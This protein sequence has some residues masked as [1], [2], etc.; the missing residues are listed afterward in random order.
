M[1]FFSCHKELPLTSV[2]QL[3][4]DNQ[5]IWLWLDFTGSMRSN[6]GYNFYLKRPFNVSQ[7]FQS[8]LNFA[9]QTAKVK[10]CPHSRKKF[11]LKRICDLTSR[12]L[13]QGDRWRWSQPRGATQIV[14]GLSLSWWVIIQLLFSETLMNKAWWI[15]TW[16]PV[17]SR[18]I[19]WMMDRMTGPK[20]AYRRRA[21]GNE[22]FFFF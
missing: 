7:S 19:R 20:E 12:W 9:T 5:S 3:C 22:M 2:V 10:W 11:E 8:P 18:E 4:R 17:P 1:L 14:Q 16:C 13:E 6:H 15:F 21:L